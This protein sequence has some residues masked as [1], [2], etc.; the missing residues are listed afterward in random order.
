MAEP[1]PATIKELKD[2]FPEKEDEGFVVEQLLANAT[3]EQANA[4]YNVVLKARLKAAQEAA[5]KPAPAPAPAAPAKTPRLPVATAA[6]GTPAP[7]QTAREQFE[8]LVEAEKA[9]GKDVFEARIAA[10]GESITLS[11]AERQR[12]RAIHRAFITEANGGREWTPM[13]A[14]R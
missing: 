4:A 13:T 12:R 9:K 5:S 11:H 8:A 6:A 1:T 3:L 14:A 7:A 2:A 10:A